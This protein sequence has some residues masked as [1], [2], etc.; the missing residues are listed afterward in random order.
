MTATP[1]TRVPDVIELGP[2]EEADRLW[3]GALEAFERAPHSL[4]ALCE[5]LDL[6]LHAAEIEAIHRLQ[7]IRRALP[8]TIA[9]Q[10]EEPVPEVDVHRDAELVS[11]ALNIT[12]ILD[13]LSEDSLPC[14]APKLHRGW[15]DRRRSCS[16]SREKARDALGF[17]LSDPEREKLL[18]LSAYRNR[19]FRC[20]PPIRVVTRDVL[21]AFPALVQLIEKLRA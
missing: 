19:I 12:E 3:T 9:L 11:K 13:L 15:E 10:L 20:P 21:D 1:P 4:V 6:G 18:L 2:R 14:V 7:P 16:R 5:S 8:G 17:G